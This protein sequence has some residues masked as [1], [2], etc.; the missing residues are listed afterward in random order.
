M[1]KMRTALSKGYIDDPPRFKKM[2]M[3]NKYFIILMGIVAS[4]VMGVIAENTRSVL[5]PPGA[6]I[7][8]DVEKVRK[9][10]GDAGLTP[11]EARHWKEIP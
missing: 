10:I 2:K 4:L 5:I 3:E 8:I 7:K 6:Q 9:Q 11:Q 1:R